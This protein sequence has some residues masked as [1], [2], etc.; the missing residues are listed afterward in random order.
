[1]IWCFIIL[2]CGCLLFWFSLDFALLYSVWVGCLLS[3]GCC[4]ICM[5]C[6]RLG[7]WWLL[8]YAYVSMWY[9]LWLTCLFSLSL[10]V[11][12]WF[13]LLFVLWFITVVYLDWV[14]WVVPLDLFALIVC[15]FVLL[16]FVWLLAYILVKGYDGVVCYWLFG[17]RL[18][19][20]LLGLFCLYLVVCCL[21]LAY[22][23]D[24]WICYF[25]VVLSGLF[26]C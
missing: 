14:V 5:F 17:F 25:I 4:V 8:G 15:L 11:S 23:L 13:A 3:C 26:G 16:L 18:F 9:W 24:L 7:V 2:V 10:V 6:L 19:D 21:V 12:C 1:M 22:I 20:W